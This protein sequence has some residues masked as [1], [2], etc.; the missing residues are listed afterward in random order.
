MRTDEGEVLASDW[1]DG[2]F[3]AISLNLG[4]WAPLFAQKQTG[5]SMMAILTQCTKPELIQMIS[6]A[7]P[8]PSEAVLKEAWRALPF[9][10]ESIYAHCKAMRFNPGPPVN[11]A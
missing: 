3:G 9:A 1:A 4:E 10:I 6:T 11:D 2:F 5:D 8:K 7:F